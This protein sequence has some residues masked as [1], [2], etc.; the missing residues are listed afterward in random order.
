MNDLKLP[1]GLVVILLSQTIAAVW[2]V[3]GL[4][5]RIEQLE[6]EVVDLAEEVEEQGEWIDELFYYVGADL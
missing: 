5:H 4:V 1:V 3:S 6:A 2:Y